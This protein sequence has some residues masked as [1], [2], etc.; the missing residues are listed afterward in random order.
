VFELSLAVYN[1]T[2]DAHYDIRVSMQT[3][4]KPVSVIYKGAITQSTGEVWHVVLSYHVLSSN[5]RS[6][7]GTTLPFS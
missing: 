6:R 7:T 4:D 2:W 5:D 3:K 1:A